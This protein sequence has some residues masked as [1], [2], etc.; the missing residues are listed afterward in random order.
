VFAQEL[1]PYEPQA[2]VSGVIRVLGNYHMETM[3]D[4]WSAGFAKH[5]PG[6]RFEKKMLGTANAIAGLYLETADIALMGREIIPMES[7][8]FRRVF[9]YDPL[10]IAVATA[11]FNVPLETFA[12]AIFVHKDNPVTRLTLPQVASLF[13]CIERGKTCGAHPWS[14]AGL[15]G[16]WANRP[17]NLYGYE[18]NTG[19]GYFFEQTVFR[20]RHLWNGALREYGNVNRPDGTVEANA[21]DLIARDLERDPNGIAFAG[22]GHVTAGVKA[23]ALAA[24]DGLPYVEL[25]RLNVLNRS[26]PLTRTV[27]VYINKPPGKPLNATLREFL[28]YVLSRE[29]QGDV[30]KQEVYLPLTA[31]LAAL[32]SKRLN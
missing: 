10:G 1:A 8:A 5:H 25:T 27:Y 14:E 17:V 31:D 24:A 15:K 26:Y 16:E 19:L 2:K 28:R 18:T 23:L 21:G 9:R 4:L 11:S 29:R 13:G 7:I 32:E 6:V 30:K 20:G 12:F 3:L 22:Y